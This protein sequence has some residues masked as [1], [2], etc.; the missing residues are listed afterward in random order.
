[1]LRHALLIMSLGLCATG[2]VSEAPQRARTVP[3]GQ[4]G[5][6]ESWWN[7]TQVR[8]QGHYENGVRQGSVSV[9]HPDGSLESSGEYEGGVPVGEMRY[10]ASGGGLRFV[11]VVHNGVLDGPRDEYDSSGRKRVTVPYSGGHRNGLEH[12]WHANGV[13]STEGRWVNDLPTS[14]WRHWDRAGRQLSQET[15]WVADG[16]AV[17]YFESTLN[18]ATGAVT[19]QA[20]KTKNGESWVGWRTYWHDNG[21]QSGLTEYVD[22]LRQGRDVSWDRQGRMS[23]EGERHGDLRNGSWL[24]WDADGELLQER[25]YLGGELLAESLEGALG[26]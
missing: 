13:L 25:V 4:N 10:Y 18:P 16:A 1:M 24:Y 11:E 3:P 7:D 22:S 6:F 12:R 17:G 14:Q 8:E 19:A 5:A 26:G 15:F 20:L 23:V 21:V 2:C 9:F